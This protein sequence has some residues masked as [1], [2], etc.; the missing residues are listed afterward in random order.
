MASILLPFDASGAID[1]RGLAALVERTA[2]AGLVPAVNLHAGFGPLLDEGA[3]LRAVEVARRAAPGRFAAGAHGEDRPSTSWNRA[4]HAR[5]MERI[6]SAGGTPVVFPSAALSALDDPAW[7]VAHRE[8]ADH[9]ERFMAC[10]LDPAFAQHGRIREARA[11]RGLL[12]IPQCVGV[13]CAFTRR[14]PEWELLALRDRHRP[15]FLVLSGNERALDMVGYGS[16][17]LLASAGLVPEAFARRD[18]L[19]THGDPAF[20]ELNDV[21]QYLASFA[22]REPLAAYRHDA[23]V[24]LELR[25]WIGCG[26]TH[27]SAISRPPGHADVLREIAQRLGV[28]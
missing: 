27:P 6:A 19:W 7:V 22:S 15:D 4:S 1:W 20:H 9:C 28:L 11:C 18:S 24:F 25:G 5:E 13:H 2:A 26:A 16:D 14:A 23:A 17:Y 3:R 8:L 12:G 10:Q 21:L